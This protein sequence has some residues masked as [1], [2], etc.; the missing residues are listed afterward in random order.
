MEESSWEIQVHIIMI[1]MTHRKRIL[2]QYYVVLQ[3][4]ILKEKEEKLKRELERLRQ[5]LIQVR[6]V[7][8]LNTLSLDNHKF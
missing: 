4:Q 7:A 2:E 1:T 5:H 8:P 3:V 6:T